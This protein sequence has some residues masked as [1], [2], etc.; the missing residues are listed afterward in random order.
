MIHWRHGYRKVLHNDLWRNIV[1]NFDAT[2]LGKFCSEELEW[3]L[4][5]F[6][7]TLNQL[8]CR[9]PMAAWSDLWLV[10]LLLLYKVDDVLINAGFDMLE[11]L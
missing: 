3:F 1:F 8:D 10:L 7:R 11:S 5:P 6:V 2:I 4:F 9:L